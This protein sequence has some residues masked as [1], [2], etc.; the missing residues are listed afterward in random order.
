[1]GLSDVAFAARMVESPDL[2]ESVQTWLD[3]EA[4]RPDDVGAE[5][6]LRFEQEKH[7]KLLVV[8]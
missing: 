2:R 6:W 7:Q 4:R 8:A 3:A 1:V 5:D